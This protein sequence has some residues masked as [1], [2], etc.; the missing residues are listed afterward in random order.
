MVTEGLRQWKNFDTKLGS[1]GFQDTTFGPEEPFIFSSVGGTGDD[2]DDYYDDQGAQTVSSTGRAHLKDDWCTTLPVASSNIIVIGGPFANL[3]AEYF[4]DFTDVYVPRIGSLQ[5]TGFYSHACWGRN[6]YEVEYVAG[7]QTT[8]YAIISTY[9]DINGTIGLIIYGWTGQDTYYACYALQHGLLEIM[10]W[11]QPGVTSLVLEFD[12]TVHPAEDCFFHIVE[13]L[14]T[15]TECS[16][17][18]YEMLWE[19]PGYYDDELIFKM[20]INSYSSE[21]WTFHC[22]VDYDVQYYWNLPD[23]FAIE[24]VYPQYIYFHWESKVHPDP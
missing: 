3:A 12:Y 7:E 20:V 8:G 9:K 19:A 6:Q 18:E 10:Q 24:I 11:L 5:T 16:G 15:I 22:Y 1:L 23:L 14:G 2:R 13:C 21:F 17:F 4:N